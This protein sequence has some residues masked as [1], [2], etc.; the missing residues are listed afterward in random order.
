MLFIY[1]FILSALMVPLEQTICGTLKT[2]LIKTIAF[3]MKN[4]KV[5]KRL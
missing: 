5:F 2:N 1:V 4:N 3:F